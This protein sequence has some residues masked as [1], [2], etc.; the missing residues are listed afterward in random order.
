MTLKTRRGF[1]DSDVL[2][3]ALTFSFMASERHLYILQG[4]VGS[5]I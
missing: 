5:V 3:V 2:L 1:E 4:S